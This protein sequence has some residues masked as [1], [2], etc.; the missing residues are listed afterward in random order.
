MHRKIIIIPPYFTEIDNTAQPERK[1]MYF[2]Y[3]DTFSFSYL[4]RK[5]AYDNYG[6]AWIYKLKLGPNNIIAQRC[7]FPYILY[8]QIHRRWG[9]EHILSARLFFPTCLLFSIFNSSFLVNLSRSSFFMSAHRW[10]S[11]P[12]K[13]YILL[14]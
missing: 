7:F 14:F 12:F 2:Q 10:D 11:I 4:C 13:E 6:W 3:V 1:S 9:K 8:H 5:P